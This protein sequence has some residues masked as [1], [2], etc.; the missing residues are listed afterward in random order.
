M[1]GRVLPVLVGMFALGARF[2]RELGRGM[3]VGAMALLALVLGAAAFALVSFDAFFAAFHAI[4]FAAGTWTFPYDSLLIQLFPERFW[5]L[6]GAAWG[7]L[8]LAL[9]V[10]AVF[11]GRRRSSG[12]EGRKS[13]SS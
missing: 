6:S 2:G 8:A 13:S 4:F 3:Q 11:L 9:A 5:A 1:D 7:A 12:S 10:A